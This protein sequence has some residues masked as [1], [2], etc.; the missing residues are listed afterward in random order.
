ML[1][2]NYIERDVAKYEKEYLVEIFDEVKT[3]YIY[4]FVIA[5]S[6]KQARNKVYSE[7]N[8]EVSRRN[9]NEYF[10]Y[11]IFKA[12]DLKVRKAYEFNKDIQLKEDAYS[13]LVWSYT[14]F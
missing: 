7:R 6:K 8:A 14:M 4:A 5:E 3:N 13:F 2:C 1:C 10:R 11:C 9:D 12:S